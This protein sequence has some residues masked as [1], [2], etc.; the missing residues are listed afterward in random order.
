MQAQRDGA[1]WLQ[2]HGSDGISQWMAQAAQAPKRMAWD[3]DYCHAASR[4]GF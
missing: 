2:Q 3:H 4:H 1:A